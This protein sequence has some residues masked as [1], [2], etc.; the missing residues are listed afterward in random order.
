MSLNQMSKIKYLSNMQKHQHFRQD[1]FE[2][3][4]TMFYICYSSIARNILPHLEGKEL[5][6]VN[7]YCWVLCY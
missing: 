2:E 5:K 3:E 6:K 7:L 4:K 1:I